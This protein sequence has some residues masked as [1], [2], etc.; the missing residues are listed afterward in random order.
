[1]AYAT[2]K[3]VKAIKSIIEML[4]EQKQNLKDGNYYSVFGF[5]IKKGKIVFTEISLIGD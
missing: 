2:N 4:K 3:E 1:M 5:T